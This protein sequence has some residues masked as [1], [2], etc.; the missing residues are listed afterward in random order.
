M[1]GSILSGVVEQW[2]DPRP[3]GQLVM[4]SVRVTL[5]DLKENVMVR[6]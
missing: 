3:V 6:G 5:T 4:S 1:T 2:A